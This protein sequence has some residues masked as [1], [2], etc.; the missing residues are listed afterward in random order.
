MATPPHAFARDSSP[1]PWSV[2]PS[3][4]KATVTVET[5][6]KV[7]RSSMKE[8]RSLDDHK[9]KVKKETPLSEAILRARQNIKKI[10][11]KRSLEETL[12]TMH[13]YFACLTFC[14]YYGSFSL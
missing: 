2:S 14:Y 3:L 4:V 13:E 8:N 10:P 1:I 9:P 7:K 5:P 11:A 12:I 6:V